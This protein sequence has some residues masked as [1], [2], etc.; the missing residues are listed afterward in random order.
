MRKVFLIFIGLLLAGVTYHKAPLLWQLKA[1][2][3]QSVCT[4]YL[5]FLKRTKEEWRMAA[6]RTLNAEPTAED[7]FG[8]SWTNGMPVCPAGGVYRIGSV[9]E[10]PACSIGGPAHS[11]RNH[12]DRPKRKDVIAVGATNIVR[13]LH[14]E[15]PRVGSGTDTSATRTIVMTNSTPEHLPVPTNAIPYEASSGNA[16]PR[17]K[18]LEIWRSPHA[19]PEQRASAITQGLPAETTIASAKAMLGRDGHLSHYFGPSFPG[20]AIDEWVLRYDRPRGCV[21]LVFSRGLG[22]TNDLRFAG[23]RMG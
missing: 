16:D 8:P 2:S 3:A 12:S 18:L 19:T 13:P 1:I 10:D 6:P 5:E 11:T 7:L 14:G 21:S 22:G 4:S 9:S 17:V 20:G 23:H 15:L